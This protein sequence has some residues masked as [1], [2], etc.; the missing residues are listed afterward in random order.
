[1][2]AAIGKL[3]VLYDAECALCCR[4]RAWL[5]R[6]PAH[7]ALE[8]IPLQSP[9]LEAR[10]PGVG[11]FRPREEIVVVADNGAVYQ[12]GRGWLMCLWALVEYRPW[13]TKLAHPTLLPMVRKFCALVSANRLSLSAL[14][15]TP[16]PM[17]VA[18]HLEVADM[19]D[20]EDGGCRM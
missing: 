8:F 1:M 18:A 14:M 13:S 20:C 3:F 9:D 11:E 5:E 12:G 7:V 19:L 4:C 6:Q 2:N 15:R 17:V 10:F 16:A